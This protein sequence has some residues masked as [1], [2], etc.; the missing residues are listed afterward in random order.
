MLTEAMRI[1]GNWAIWQS[2]KCFGLLAILLAL[3][4]C[5]SDRSTEQQA[6]GDLRG[7]LTVFAAASL[8]DAFREVADAFESRNPAVEVRFNFG[9]SPTLRTQLEQGARADVFAS[10][11]QDQMNL[12]V[13][14][15]V[16]DR[17]RLFA[18]NSLVVITP[19]D[20]P[21]R[22]E[23]LSDLRKPGL[24]LVLA[25]ADV[26]AGAYTRE[27]LAAAEKESAY[28]DGFS[29]AVLRNAVSLES[30]VKQVVAKVEL[31]EADAGVVYGSDVTA[32]VAPKLRT[33]TI[34][35]Q[36]NVIAE[37]PIG[38]TREAGNPRAAEAF[39]DFVLSPAGQA[40]LEKHSFLPLASSRQ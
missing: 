33:V 14:S 34:P 30:N 23:S 29:A 25:N 3:L 1:W 28:G 39:I 17:G 38:I 11:D 13:M 16:V 5:G 9:G 37:Y 36:L 22:I 2:G 27:M 4:S 19:A 18:R 12:A 21:G 10:A 8:T 40:V 7:E 31:G 6:A 24:K 26:P 15:R 20:N 35:S 32:G